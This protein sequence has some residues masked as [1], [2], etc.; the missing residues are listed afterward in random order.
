MVGSITD[1]HITKEE[2]EAERFDDVPEDS[3]ASASE[4][5]FRNAAMQI[6]VQRNDF[7]LPN[8]IDMLVTHKTVEVSPYYQRR[9]R[10]DT[11][12]KSKLIESFWL[13]SLCHLSSCTKMISQGMK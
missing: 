2:L 8:L 9:A 3:I 10:W 12:R 13:I 7:L 4:Q 11:A 5:E 1:E 6:I